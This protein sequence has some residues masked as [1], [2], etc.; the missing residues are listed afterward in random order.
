[1]SS[2]YSQGRNA[3]QLQ[4]CASASVLNPACE[5]VG[6][7]SKDKTNKPKNK[8][9][10]D[11]PLER[12]EYKRDSKSEVH[13]ILIERC[14]MFLWRVGLGHVLCICEMS[15]RTM[16]DTLERLSLSLCYSSFYTEFVLLAKRY[17]STHT[18]SLEFNIG[19]YCAVIWKITSFPAYS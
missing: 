11:T 6:I 3:C 12:V 8:Q 5:I 17:Q 14:S 13:S 7:T 10:K 9:N 15:K 19:Q 2:S 18:R 16:L 4:V 1:M